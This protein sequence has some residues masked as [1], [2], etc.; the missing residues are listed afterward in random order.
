V[1]A[2]GR[3]QWPDGRLRHR[4]GRGGAGRGLL[5]KYKTGQGEAGRDFSSIINSCG[6]R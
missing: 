6:G 4:S 5:K 1:L 3:C 2:Q